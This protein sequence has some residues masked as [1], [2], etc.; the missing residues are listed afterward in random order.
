M[1]HGI[2]F[3]G[4]ILVQGLILKN[5]EAGYLINPFLYVLFILSLP[6]ELPAWIGLLLAF[7]LGFFVDIFYGT[8]GMHMAACTMMGW[9]RP[10]ILKFMNPRDGYEFGMQ[11]TIQDMGRMWF[12]SYAAI[13]IFVHHFVLF[14]LEIFSFREVWLTFVRVLVSTAATLLLVI[15]TQFLFYRKRESA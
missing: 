14:Y 6:F 1:R 11:P 12:I 8:M 13:L 9:A 5:L 15:I 3:I 7:A 10:A 4:L 2:R